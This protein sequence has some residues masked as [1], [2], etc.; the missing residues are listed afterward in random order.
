MRTPRHVRAERQ[1]AMADD[2]LASNGIHP[3][4]RKAIPPN[5]WDDLIVSTIRGQAWARRNR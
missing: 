2:E 1:I 5:A 3:R 4:T